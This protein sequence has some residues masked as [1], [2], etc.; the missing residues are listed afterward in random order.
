[1]ARIIDNKDLSDMLDIFSGA[2]GC[3]GFFYL[4][5]VFESQNPEL[6]KLQDLIALKAKEFMKL[7]TLCRKLIE[8]SNQDRKSS[9]ND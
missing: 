4:K 3:A 2:D 8:K 9:K 6:L 1:M 5:Y 7:T